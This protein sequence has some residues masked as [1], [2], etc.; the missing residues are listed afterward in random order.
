M[1]LLN[2]LCGKPYYKYPLHVL[3]NSTEY[4]TASKTEACKQHCRL[5]PRNLSV[6]MQSDSNRTPFFFTLSLGERRNPSNSVLHPWRH[7][8]FKEGISLERGI[9]QVPRYAEFPWTN[10]PAM[11]KRRKKLSIGKQIPLLS[12]N[13]KT[14]FTYKVKLKWGF[15]IFYPVSWYLPKGFCSFHFTSL[16]PPNAFGIFRIYYSTKLN[17]FFYQ[18]WK[19]EVLQCK[20]E[21]LCNNIK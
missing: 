12:T 6:F 15:H 17:I 16:N 2:I 21:T 3:L 5:E 9:C 20:S 8:L 13:Q 7:K 19:P 10:T 4:L 1:T 14:T 18:M 11:G